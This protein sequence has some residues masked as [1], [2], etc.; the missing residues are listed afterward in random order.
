M[1]KFF[2][3]GQM[4][5]YSHWRNS[6]PLTTKLEYR[7]SLQKLFCKP[8]Q[9]KHTIAQMLSAKTVGMNN[10]FEIHHYPHIV[11]RNIL[12]SFLLNHPALL[13]NQ[14]K[15][16]FIDVEQFNPISLMNHLKIKLK[17]V[18]LKTDIDINYLKNEHNI[19]Q[20]IQGLEDTKIK[21]RC[22]QSMDQLPSD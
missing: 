21:Y 9:P 16:K 3:N 14:I 10:F 4:V 13:K 19:D 20:F 15:Y 8:I 6:L 22:I 18:S 5:V 1:T 12:K 11:D 2:D 17:E 7:K